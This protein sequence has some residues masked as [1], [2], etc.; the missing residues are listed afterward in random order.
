MF[1]VVVVT[2]AWRLKRDRRRVCRCDANKRNCGNR[3]RRSRHGEVYIPL[4]LLCGEQKR[5]GTLSRAT[6]ARGSGKYPQKWRLDVPSYNDPTI[7]KASISVR[8]F[9]FEIPSL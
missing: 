3:E 7:F 1:A 6:R 8:R 4:L 5:R 9:Y 2:F